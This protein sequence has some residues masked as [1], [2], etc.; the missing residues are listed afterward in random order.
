MSGPAH[1]AAAVAR[2]GERARVGDRRQIGARAGRAPAGHPTT[3]PQRT[4]EILIGPHLE[5]AREGACG[6]FRSATEIREFVTSRLHETPLRLQYVEVVR[7]QDLEPVET[8][9]GEIVVAAAVHL[10]ATR[11]IDNVII[12]IPDPEASPSCEGKC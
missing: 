8:L 4:T 11:L 9:Q 12:N 5:G 6:R 3:A 7:A 1:G 2:Q 10:G